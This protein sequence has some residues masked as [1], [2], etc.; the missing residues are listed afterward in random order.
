MDHTQW[1]TDQRTILKT[2]QLPKAALQCHPHIHLDH[3]D[4]QPI[5]FV[6][7]IIAIVR[8]IEPAIQMERKT[9]E[10]FVVLYLKQPRVET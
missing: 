9:C 3:P 4:L 10:A 6:V 7:P 2:A 8:P 1:Q 5:H